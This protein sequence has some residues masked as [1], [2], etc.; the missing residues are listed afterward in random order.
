MLAPRC[1]AHQVKLSKHHRL[2]PV[3]AEPNLEGPRARESPRFRRWPRRLLVLCAFVY[4]AGLIALTLGFYCIGERWWVTAAG[5]YAPRLP[6]VLPLPLLVIALWLSGLRRYLWTQLVAGVVAFVPFMGFVPPRLA[7]PSD[8]APRLR[9]LSF[10]VN[11]AF[12][13]TQLIADEIA[14]HSPDIALLQEGPYY[15]GQLLDALRAHFPYVQSSTQFIVASRYPLVSSNEPKSVRFYGRL[16]APGFMRYVFETPLGSLVVY[17]VH[18]TSPRGVLHL[19]QF[20]AALHQLETGELFAGDPELDVASNAGLRA[21]QIGTAA[22]AAQVESLP[23]LI[24]GDTNLPGLSTIFREHLSRFNDGF[25]AVGWGF[26]YTYTNKH[27]FLRL[28][29]ILVSDKLGFVSFQV[30]C[31]GVSDHLC[32]VADIQARP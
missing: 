6:F 30:A 20:R 3:P 5:L 15:N 17:S 13:G 2:V 1:L 8:T 32:V 19:R 28:D 12:G 31:P 4:P 29:R 7:R 10:N 11:T 23:V 14:A 25:A 27:P 18:P 22:E 24:A 26:G 21:L 16:H 9:V